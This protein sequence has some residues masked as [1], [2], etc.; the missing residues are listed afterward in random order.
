MFLSQ[1]MVNTAGNPDQPRPGKEWVRQTYRVHQRIWMAFPDEGRRKADP[2]FLGNWSDFRTP[3][4]RRS[5]AGFLFRIEPDLPTRVLVQS[6]LRPDW[7]YAFQNAKHLLAEAPLVREF[8]PGPKVGQ[9]Y[10]FRLA[11]LMVKRATRKDDEKGKLTEHPIRCLVPATNPEE[12]PRPDPTFR[13][14]REK[15]ASEGDRT[16]S[17]RA[18]TLPAFPLSPSETSA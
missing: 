16:A 11:M 7:E 2:F 15:L 14:W 13:A 18:I 1:L 6:V 9:T 8:D 17:N 10:K 4:P 12:P 5:E 3:K